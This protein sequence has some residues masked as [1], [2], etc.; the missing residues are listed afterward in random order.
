MMARGFKLPAKNVLICIG[1]EPQ[2]LEF[3]PYAKMLESMGF[4][5]YCTKNTHEVTLQPTR[6]H[7]HVFKRQGVETAVLVYKPLVKREPNTST[8][9]SNGKLDLVCHIRRIPTP[10]RNLRS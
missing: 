1:P 5:L 8:L 7:T 10:T 2:K 3:L 9:L 4:Q 6:A